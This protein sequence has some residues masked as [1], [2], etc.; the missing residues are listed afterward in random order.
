VGD[1]AFV[2][3]T[4]PTMNLDKSLP[5]DVRRVEV[6]AYTSLTPPPRA[7]FLEGARLVG[8]FPVVPLPVEPGTEPSTKPAK[9]QPPSP[10]AAGP[11]G[12]DGAL[13]G[14]AI[15]IRDALGADDDK[16]HLFGRKWP[17]DQLQYSPVQL[18]LG[19]DAV[20]RRADAEQ[21]A[22]IALGARSRWRLVCLPEI[23]RVVDRQAGGRFDR[24][25]EEWRNGRRMRVHDE[26]EYRPTDRDPVAIDQRMIRHLRAVDE[27]AVRTLGIANAP[28]AVGRADRAVHTRQR[29]VRDAEAL[30]PS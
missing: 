1:D 15:T 19:R 4:V 16:R 20:Q 3:L 18:V 7:R 28:C 22:K 8:T 27:R 6:Y 25:V 26:Q 30:R 11:V 29:Q 23:D 24:P 5:V 17:G 9:P 21:C 14:T 2:T 12:A 13:P 10:A